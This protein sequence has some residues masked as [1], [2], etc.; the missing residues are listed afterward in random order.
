M[1]SDFKEML[2]YVLPI[3]SIAV[4]ATLP[5]IVFLLLRIFA[6]K[7]LVEAALANRLENEESVFRLRRI[8]LSQYSQSKKGPQKG[9]REGQRKGQRKGPPKVPNKTRS[10]ITGGNSRNS[11]SRAAT[12]RSRNPSPRNPSSR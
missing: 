12:P 7:D 5:L 2:T 9:P 11:K 8:Q 10:A 3:L 4:V 1:P 6:R